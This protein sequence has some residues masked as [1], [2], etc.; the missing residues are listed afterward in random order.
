MDTTEYGVRRVLGVALGAVTLAALALAGCAAVE[1]GNGRP[2]EAMT[3]ASDTGDTGGSSSAA[4]TT[5]PTSEATL[6]VSTTAASPTDTGTTTGSEDPALAFAI[7]YQFAAHV[8]TDNLDLAYAL[9]CADTRAE[10]TLEDFSTGAP[11]PGTLTF[12]PGEQIGPGQFSG[13]LLYEGET[14]DIILRSDDAGSYCV[15]GE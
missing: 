10:V 9:L 7:G 1:E 14:D 13:Q 6:T 4:P 8:N 5:A 15:T 12:D 3:S 2:G 11:T